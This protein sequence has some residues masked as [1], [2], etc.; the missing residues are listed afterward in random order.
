M[1]KIQGYLLVA[2][3]QQ[4]KLH[5]KNLFTGGLPGGTVVNFAHSTSMAWGSAVRIL[6]VDLHTTCQA[7]LWQA[8]HI[9]SKGRWAWMLAQGQSS[10]AKRGKLAA[11][12]SSGLIFLKN[13]LKK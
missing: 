10:S 7:L 2:T 11:D 1:Q 13:N 6:G 12:I 4:A 9:E 3:L 8:S 5:H